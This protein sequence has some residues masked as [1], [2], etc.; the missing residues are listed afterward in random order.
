MSRA[1][2]NNLEKQWE[3]ILKKYGIPAYRKQERR[4]NFSISVDDVGILGYPSIKSDCKYRA[5]GFA[6][7]TLLD[8]VESKYCKTPEDF[9]ILICK[10]KNERGQKVVIDSEVAAMLLSYWLGFNTKEDLETIRLQK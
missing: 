10:G 6:A 1:A 9:A 4:L 8:E 3:K 7:N 5:S 2:G